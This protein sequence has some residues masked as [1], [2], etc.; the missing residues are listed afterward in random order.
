[1]EGSPDETAAM[2]ALRERLGDEMVGHF[3]YRRK[4]MRHPRPLTGGEREMIQAAI[5]P[6]LRDLQ[7]S[8]AIVPEVHYEGH[9]ERGRVGAWF[10]SGGDPLL[11]YPAAERVVRLAGQ[12]QEWE[13]EQLAKAGRSA[14]WPECPEHPDSHPLEPDVNDEDVPVWY[15][16]R[17]KD[18]ICD[19]GALASRP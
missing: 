17:S 13:I 3:Q 14:T 6:V 15:C 1:M 19:I 7:A 4:L 16:P 12:V 18:V 2:A 5:A 10:F 11:D 9:P 8:G